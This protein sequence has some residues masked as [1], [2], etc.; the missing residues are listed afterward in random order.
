MLTS[1]QLQDIVK[2]KNVIFF[3]PF[4]PYC[5]AAQFLLDRLVKDQKIQSYQVIMLGNDF[6]N[7]TLLELMQTKDWKPTSRGNYPTKPQIFIEGEYIGGNQE[8]YHSKWNI[9]QGM[10]NLPL[11]I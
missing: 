8:F 7:D 9:G 2:T 11:V 1:I 10:P 5:I 4:C 6:D 3:K